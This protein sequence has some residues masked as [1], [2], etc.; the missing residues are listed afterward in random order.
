MKPYVTFLLTLLTANV[1]WAAEP[2][3]CPQIAGSY[4][5]S[6]T[7]P[8][9]VIIEQKNGNE[10]SLDVGSGNFPFVANGIEVKQTSPGGTETNTEFN[11]CYG[12]FM[13]RAASLQIL[14]KTNTQIDMFLIF[15]KLSDTGLKFTTVVLTY[16]DGVE[17]KDFSTEKS[18]SCTKIKELQ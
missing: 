3:S 15:Q 17:N 14:D 2:V 4:T 10:F 6:N 8:F 5:C 18:Y 13:V 16:V 9:K 11:S 1:V 12:N 7:P